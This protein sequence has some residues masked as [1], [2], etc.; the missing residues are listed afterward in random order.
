MHN[1]IDLGF[2]MWDE[3]LDNSSWVL[4]RKELVVYQMPKLGDDVRIITYPAGIQRVFAYRDFWALDAAGNTLA[5][6]SSTWTLM[7]LL[8]RKMTPIPKRMFELQEVVAG[9]N[10]PIPAQKL[11]PP[12]TLE[13]A[14]V[15]KVGHYDL[16]WNGHVNNVVMTRL[17]L[18]GTSYEVYSRQQIVSFKY[19]VKAE[20]LPEQEVTVSIGQKEGSYY[21]ELKSVEGKVLAVGESVW[22]SR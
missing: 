10:L 17:L 5:Y 1:A 4:L 9:Q 6:A 20:L 7:N 3:E 2:S 16:D 18:Q 13:E 12:E 8:T 21:H 19:Q 15:Y 14:Y 11:S 22:S